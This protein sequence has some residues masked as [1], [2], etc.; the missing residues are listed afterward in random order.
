MDVRFSSQAAPGRTDNE[1]G[2]LTVGNL[3][4]VFDGVTQA[5]GIE[6]GCIHGPAWYVRHLSHQLKAAYSK[7]PAAPLSDLLALAISGVADQHRTT[8]DLTSRATPASTAC[9]LRE[10][11]DQVEYL[12]LCDGTLVLDRG[13]RVETVTDDRFSRVIAD[14]RRTEPAYAMAS[15]VKAVTVEKWQY[16]NRPD[17]YWIA[18]ADPQAAYEAVTGSIPLN[19][20]DRLRRAALL[21][22]GASAAVDQFGLFDWNGLLDIL[23]NAGPAHLIHKVRTAENADRPA[24]TRL[25]Y[26]RHDD[27]TAAICLFEGTDL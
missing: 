9:L 22:D 19:G 25:R 12:V 3:V 10:G 7:A 11:T 21:T 27:A 23:T 1:D 15:P 17:G 6:S 26:K 18:A 4:A 13:G 16:I 5:P 20:P 14:L 2:A 24:D 8:C